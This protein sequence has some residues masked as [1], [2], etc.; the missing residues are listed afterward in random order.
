MI[1]HVPGAADAEQVT[2]L[3]APNRALSRGA[4]RQCIAI[5]V[6]AAAVVALLASWQGNVFAPLFA[7][8]EAPCIAVALWVA[9]RAGERRERITLDVRSLRIEMIPAR[10]R[11]VAFPS[12][13]VRVRLRD[14][15]GHRHVLLAACGREREVGAFLGDEERLELSKQ[16]RVLLAGMS[17]SRNS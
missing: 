11:A 1:T 15:G 4:L 17:G 9:W 6:L 10:G 14:W 3:L 7:L 16:L 8:L 2:L 12:A 5:L 13:W